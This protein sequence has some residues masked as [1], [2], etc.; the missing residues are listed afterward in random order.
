MTSLQKN[1]LLLISQSAIL[2]LGLTALETLFPDNR[3][4]GFFAFIL[5]AL[6]I[7]GG[8][9]LRQAWRHSE[10][11]QS[12]LEALQHAGLPL[13]MLNLQ[14][15]R[16]FANQA[17]LDLDRSLHASA[18]LDA[19]PPEW[20]ES[21]HRHIEQALSSQ[22]RSVPEDVLLKPGDLREAMLLRLIAYRVVDTHGRDCIL[23]SA[24]N[25]TAHNQTLSA[26]IEREHALRTRT[27]RY[28]QTLI[29]VI[30]Q[31]V[32]VKDEEG[33]FVLVNQT[34]CA[35]HNLSQKDLLGQ[36]RQVLH[37]DILRAEEALREDLRVMAGTPIFREEHLSSE[38]QDLYFIISKQSCE[39]PEGRRVLVGTQVD[40]TPWRT[41]EQAVKDALERETDRRERT[42]AFVQRL[43]DV[44]PY[45]VCLKNE[46]SRYVMFNEAFVNSRGKSRSE[47][48]DQDAMQIA[49]AVVSAESGLREFAEQRAHLSNQEDQAVL[50]GATLSKEE[51]EV[52][53]QHGVLHDRIV[54]KS[55]CEDPDGQKLIVVSMFDIT[56]MRNAQ[57]EMSKT[58][59]AEKSLRERTDAFIQRLI[60]VI[61]HPVY[62]KNPAGQALLVNEA[63]INDC[64]RPREELI[65]RT[66]AEM[67]RRAA[68]GQEALLE[69]LQERGQQSSEEDLAVLA[70]QPLI[71][72]VSNVHV[73]TGRHLDR[74]VSKAACA[75]PNGNPVIVVAMFDITELRSIQREMQKSLERE[76][77]RRERTQAFVQRLL[78]VLPYPVSIKNSASQYLIVN[79]AFAESRG[80]NKEE[81]VNKTPDQVLDMIAPDNEALRAA[82]NEHARIA[83]EEDREVL[84]GA[85]IRK[86]TNRV[87]GYTGKP[88]DLI[89]TKAACEDPEGEP[90]IVT[91]LFDITELRET[92]RELHHALEAATGRSERIQAFI[93]RLLNVIPE[94]VYVKDAQ[95]RYIMINEAF[96]AQRQQAPEDILFKSARELAPSPDI[97]DKVL[98][99]D[100]EVIAGK[101][102]YRVDDTP[103]PLT[104]QPR[105][106]IISK[107]SCLDPEGLPVIVGTNIDITRVRE[108]EKKLADTLAAER[109]LRERTQQYIQSLLD[110]IPLPICVRDQES[111]H[112]QVN[113]TFIEES[114]LSLEAIL[115]K[116]ITDFQT[117]PIQ[118]QSS[119]LEDQQALAG[120]AV[121]NEK[122][123]LGLS[124][125]DLR[126]RIISKR[127]CLDVDQQAVIVVVHID[128]TAQREAER[129]A[130][131][132]LANEKSLRQRTQNFIQR[133]IDVIPHPFF[134]KNQESRY[135]L[136]NEAHLQELQRSAEEVIGRSSAELAADPARIEWILHEDQRVLSGEDV[137]EERHERPIIG[138]ETWQ[139]RLITKRRCLDV[140]GKP[141]IAC[142]HIDV[143]AHRNIERALQAALA[144]ESSSMKE[145]LQHVIDVLP[146][147]FYIKDTK[148]RVLMANPVYL[149]RRGLQRVEEA[150]GKTAPEIGDDFLKRFPELEAAPEALE[151]ARQELHHHW[152]LA[153]LEDQEVLQ[154][155]RILKR[156]L[157]KLPGRE[158][159][160]VLIVSKAACKGPEN[161]PVIVCASYDLSEI[162]AN[163]PLIQTD[164]GVKKDA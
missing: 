119:M 20:R 94:P 130:M 137:N 49:S 154:G 161:K 68:S 34:F 27:Q 140:D 44:V 66:H 14:R 31:P 36:A 115:G 149:N 100:T 110:A 111:R 156:M 22:G 135:V 105:W 126:D 21:F 5:L 102:I 37:A 106:R 61:P 35:R 91:S 82:S 80:R 73:F 92:Q 97:A 45:P 143:T 59:Q 4:P 16:V 69:E 32:Y 10:S 67:S 7:I 148:G 151:A 159:P 103:H 70:G 43:L 25:L 153:Q 15:E 53:D 41:A 24:E 128:V 157:R 124:G 18:Q 101:V 109:D 77:Q 116:R 50:A 90:V 85:R 87:I 42:Q 132:L 13:L 131:A 62:V 95:A 74:I 117:D 123:D 65:G 93:Q 121:F 72:E 136:A 46:H 40:I 127:R 89:V 9:Q 55:L 133:M 51:N 155:K 52:P 138:G 64:R 113:S 104:G 81:I 158:A 58:L 48:L 141:V 26:A 1:I 76:T 60:D 152:N 129:Q 3:G 11:S 144:R 98:A 118:I 134:I 125:Q 78:D 19:F 162:D 147:E 84:A 8:T 145:F 75:D 83:V 28:V 17:F 120:E 86:E 29:D 23:I 96:A 12:L 163:T 146:Q 57:R 2:A 47:L 33:R 160:H 54:S 56:D 38:G 122:Q 108:V 39:D 79:D 114:H 139:D 63:F 142:S 107:G 150:L 164:S 6:L 30:P 71:K 112:L 88:R 99:E